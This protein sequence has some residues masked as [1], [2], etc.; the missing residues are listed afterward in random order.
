MATRNVDDKAVATDGQTGLG[1]STGGLMIGSGEGNQADT[2]WS[3]L[4]DDV[5]IYSRVVTP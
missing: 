1:G 3:G 2:F 4:F 5:R